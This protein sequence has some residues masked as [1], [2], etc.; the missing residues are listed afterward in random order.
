MPAL[1]DEDRARLRM[2]V[3]VEWGEAALAQDW[4]ASMALCTDDFVYLPQD[5]PALHGKDEAKAFLESFPRVVSF[6]QSLENID[7]T[8]ELASVHGSFSMT[9][10]QDGEEIGGEEKFLATLR[11]ERGEWLMSAGCFN[12]NAPPGS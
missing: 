9:V 7:G 8:T 3:E 1:T 2:F 12:C 4:D 10:E 5:H 6:S 11:K